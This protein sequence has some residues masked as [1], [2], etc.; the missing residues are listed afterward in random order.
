[1]KKCDLFY[2]AIKEQKVNFLHYYDYE[3]PKKMGDFF[4]ICSGGF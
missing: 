3:I 4:Y 1:M 2:L